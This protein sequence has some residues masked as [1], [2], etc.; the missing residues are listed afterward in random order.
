MPDSFGTFLAG[1]RKV[2]IF[3]KYKHVEPIQRL[4]KESTRL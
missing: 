1:T 2:R 3:S 4:Q